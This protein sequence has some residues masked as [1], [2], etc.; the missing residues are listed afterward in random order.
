[1]NG[2][3]LRELVTRGRRI[4][5]GHVFV[6]CRLCGV[7]VDTATMPLNEQFCAACAL[8]SYAHSWN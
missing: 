5:A 3:A 8:A 1:V 6:P 4:K 7:P 2:D